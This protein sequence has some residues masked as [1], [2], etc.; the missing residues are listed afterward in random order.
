MNQNMYAL[1]KKICM[2]SS[3]LGA[4]V[5]LMLDKL[6]EVWYYASDCVKPVSNLDF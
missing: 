3:N 2:V 4:I 5:F 1:M 6:L